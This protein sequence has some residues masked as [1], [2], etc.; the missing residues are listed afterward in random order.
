M[1]Q[2]I[3]VF[4]YRII[5][6]NPIGGC[7]LY[8]LQGLCH[9]HDFTVFAVE[10][11]NP[12]PERIR[13]VRIPAF[14]R[15]LALLF[16]L[17][18]VLAPLYY[19]TY[20]LR[21]RIRFDLV[22]IVGSDVMFGNVAYVQFC[23]RTYLK[24]YWKQSRPRGVR[25]RLRWL[26]HR[27]RSMLE[28]LVFRRVAS[29][30]VPSQ[31]L[32]RELA[33]EYPHARA[34]IHTIPNPVDVERMH[35]SE[36]FDRDVYRHGL[37][38]CAEDILLVF[39][40]LGHFERKG[41]PLLL[42]ALGKLDDPRLK[43]VVVG[44]ERDL[45]AVYQARVEQMGLSSHVQ[46]AGMQ[47]DIRSYLWA[48]DAFVF[49]S[50]YEAFPLVALEAAACGLPLIVTPING[51]EEFLSDGKNGILV[52][53]TPEAVA[54]GLKRFLLLTPEARRAM[55]REAQ[56]DVERYRQERFVAAWRDLYASWRGT[57]HDLETTCPAR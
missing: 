41:L 22:Q 57:R 44:G 43:L 46:F 30:V 52:A 42:E 11:E 38:L 31:G 2:K 34:K 35:L 39:V 40:A 19:W 12:C 36:G 17:Y 25:G 6:T 53:Q 29:I 37:K 10:F 50:F 16:V 18:H 7:H 24:H 8:I 47:R 55:G 3:A 54:Y 5:P 28:P 56:R 9:E 1:G 51:V 49:P 23:N 27:L 14:T 32:A 21:H 48:A 20:R 13:W 26:N 4:D 15:P 45:V 33:T